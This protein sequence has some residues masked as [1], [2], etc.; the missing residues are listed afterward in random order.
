[1]DIKARKINSTVLN[2]GTDPVDYWGFF[3]FMG[4]MDE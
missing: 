4:W 3:F 1:M 2:V